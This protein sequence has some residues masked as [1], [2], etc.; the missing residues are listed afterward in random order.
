MQPGNRSGPAGVEYARGWE[1]TPGPRN[2]HGNEQEG[3]VIEDKANGDFVTAKRG[4][5]W[6]FPRPSGRILGLTGAL[7]VGLLVLAAAGAT[8]ATVRYSNEYEGRALPGTTVAGVPIDGMDR[9]AAVVAVESALAPRLDREITVTYGKKDWTITPREMGARS[10]AR[11]AV[12]EALAASEDAS[13]VTRMRMRLLGEDFD[14]IAGVQLRYPR[15]DA[16]AFVAGLAEE[17][18]RDPRDASIDYSTGWVELVR[19]QEG[20]KVLTKKSQQSLMGALRGNDPQVDLQVKT[21]APAVT[22]DSFDKILLLHIGENRL[23][24]YEN[25]KITNQWV[26]ATGLPEYPTPTGLYEVTEKR[27]MPTWVNPDPEGWG[28]S[29]PASIGPGPGN[30]LGTRALNWS[31]SG[32]RFHGT[33]ATYS[34]GYN[35][36]HGCVRMAM[37]DVEALYDMIDVGTPI[38]SVTYGSYDPLADGAQNN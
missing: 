17:L 21:I 26:V 2:I 12:T 9:A 25:G 31:A 30:P 6:R 24:L 18:N 16:K 8:Y 13:F 4:L 28:A 36:S 27:Y 11:A 15:R 7:L 10:T 33:E 22:A 5:S 1:K 37:A 14:Y 20:R 23:F 35:A 3:D 32:I 34:L 29:M 19:E 38:V